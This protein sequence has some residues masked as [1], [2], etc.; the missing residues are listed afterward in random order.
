MV[1][2]ITNLY[3]MLVYASWLFHD[4]IDEQQIDSIVFQWH[5]RIGD[6]K[7]IWFEKVMIIH[8]MYVCRMN[9][10]LWGP[11]TSMRNV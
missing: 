10:F 2:F 9:L 1:L 11:M 5:H 4:I 3:I 7:T 8:V 6:M